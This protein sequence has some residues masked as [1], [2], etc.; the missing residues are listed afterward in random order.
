MMC[1]LTEV[2][3]GTAEYSTKGLTLHGVSCPLVR[4]VRPTIV[5]QLSLPKFWNLYSSHTLKTKQLSPH[6]LFQSV[7][8]VMPPPHLTPAGNLLLPFPEGPVQGIG[9]GTWLRIRPRPPPPPGLPPG[10]LPGQPPPP[11]GPPPTAEAQLTSQVISHIENS[12]FLVVDA[13]APAPPQI[14]ALPPPPP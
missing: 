13:D 2:L 9:G 10:V 1:V 3:A 6:T 4:Y 12:D 14:P 5:S 7:T 11:P 8:Q